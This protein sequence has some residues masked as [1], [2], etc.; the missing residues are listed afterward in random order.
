MSGAAASRI[1]RARARS[2][3]GLPVIHAGRADR[4][5]PGSELAPG[6]RVEPAVGPVHAKQGVAGGQGA[7]PLDHDVRG[8][9]GG[10]PARAPTSLAGP[11][12][13]VH[14][15]PLRNRL[16]GSL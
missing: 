11:S 3:D 9:L 13:R 7:N 6:A 14:A 15:W 10:T 12:Y 8:H 1:E 4:A 16:L 2:L 5:G